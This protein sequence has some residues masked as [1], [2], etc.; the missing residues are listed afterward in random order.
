MSAR[1]KV[2]G[3]QG[4]RQKAPGSK[5]TYEIVAAPSKAA[6]ARAAGYVAP[7][8][9]FNLCETGNDDD[10]AQAL[11]EPGVVFWRPLDQIPRER[12]WV[13]VAKEKSDGSA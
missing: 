2:Y 12:K 7:R 3:W 13:R 9:M 6:A 8:Q 5:Q 1:L 4:C 10:V 11:S